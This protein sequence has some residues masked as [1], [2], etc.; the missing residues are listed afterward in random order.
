MSDTSSFSAR[1]SDGPRG[2]LSFVPAQGCGN[3]G[4]TRIES[5]GEWRVLGQGV[6]NELPTSADQC[7]PEG[8]AAG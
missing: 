5:L 4:E 2:P 6:A 8:F 7:V 3:P 1:P